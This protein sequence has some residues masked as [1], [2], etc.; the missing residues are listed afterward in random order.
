MIE[1]VDKVDRR[2]Q[3][4]ETALLAVGGKSEKNLRSIE[5]DFK[6]LIF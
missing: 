6:K 5:K 3:M 2:M 1:L 4:I